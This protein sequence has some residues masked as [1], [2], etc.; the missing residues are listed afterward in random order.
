MERRWWSSNETM[1]SPA[2]GLA[3]S[4]KQL[5]HDSKVGEGNSR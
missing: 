1:G 5:A 2:A 4:K 3:R